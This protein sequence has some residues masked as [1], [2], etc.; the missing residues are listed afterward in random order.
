MLY[1]SK[2]VV[3]DENIFW[4]PFFLLSPEHNKHVSSENYSKQLESLSTKV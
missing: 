1:I 4:K 3:T 2:N